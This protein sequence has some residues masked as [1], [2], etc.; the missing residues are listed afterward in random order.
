MINSITKPII[1]SG[2]VSR[3]L[4]IANIS[5]ALIYLSWWFNF[6]HIGNPVLYA[7][8]FLGEIYHLFIALMFWYTIWPVKKKR[9]HS[10]HIL[11]D[12]F[13]PSVDIFITVAGEPVEIVRQTAIAALQQ[14]YKDHKVYLLNDGFVAQKENWME[15]EQLA[16]ELKIGCITRQTGGGAKAGNIN[17]ALR[18][19]IG[20]IIVIFDADMVPHSDFLL[21]ML[22]YFEEKLMGF[23]QSPQ[24]YKNF[25][26]NEVTN[27]SWEQ[28][29]FF[30]GPV[31]AGKNNSNSAF[32][33]GTNVAI[34]RTA[35]NEVGG[36]YEKSIAE[37][38]LTSLFIHQKGWKSHYVTEVLSEGLAP[39]DLLSYYKQQ[40]RWA[41]GSLEVLF[42]SNPLFKSGL[43]FKQKL[44]YLVS[45]LYYFNGIVVLI[46]ILMPLGY[47]F[48]GLQPVAATTTSF[49]L[50]FI[51]FMFLN[52]YT[53][54]SISNASMTFRAI[55]F[56]Q[57]SWTL[58][59]VALKSVILKQ[60]MK[61]AVTPK[62]QQS[63]NFIFLVYPHLLY[64]VITVIAVFVGIG[65]EGFN[66]SISTN[67]AWALFNII[68]FLPFIQ[69]SFHFNSKEKVRENLALSGK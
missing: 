23:V 5:M 12:G 55:S 51:P 68:L 57:A 26:R 10:R 22:P 29:E 52:L 42:G 46:D 32:I 18:Q 58:Q 62:Q 67:I 19:T 56:S 2:E 34:R 8:L 28:Q 54:Y 17:N 31:M 41:R 35:L 7:L 59:L 64:T 36:I 45:A 25:S 65:R 43:T 66:P 40:L 49:A 15:I 60:N 3:L 33:C 39:E 48:F 4:L 38:F 53:L 44:Q 1:N 63:G 6:S 24:Y 27:G 50:Y 20:E 21:K 14:E 9:S 11:H 13:S 69:A 30:F 37:D 61:F 47:L 16:Q